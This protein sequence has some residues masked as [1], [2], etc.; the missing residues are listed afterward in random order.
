VAGRLDAGGAV[1]PRRLPPERA[2]RRGTGFTHAVAPTPGSA[3]LCLRWEG[4]IAEAVAQLTAAGV[5]VELGPVGRPASD[6]TRGESVYF[7]DPD[8]NL[9]ELLTVTP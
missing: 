8:G 5:A 1:G 2:P 4:T 7:R 6:G 3:D 9:L